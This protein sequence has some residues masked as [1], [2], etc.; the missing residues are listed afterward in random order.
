MSELVETK[1]HLEKCERCKN[2][3]PIE[4]TIPINYIVVARNRWVIYCKDCFKKAIMEED[5]KDAT[6]LLRDLLRLNL[7]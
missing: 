2:K 7:L 3:V 4:M 1:E 5:A 6:V